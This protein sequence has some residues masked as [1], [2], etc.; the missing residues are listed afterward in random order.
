M[1]DATDGL[2]TCDTMTIR[3]EVTNPCVLTTLVFPPLSNQTVYLD[4]GDPLYFGV[5]FADQ[6][7]L[8]KGNYD[9]VSFCGARRYEFSEP[10][11]VTESEGRWAIRAESS[12]YSIKESPIAV[13]VWVTLDYLDASILMQSL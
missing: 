10:D 12:K 2:T 1:V 8:V 4:D 9:G 11:L 6:I 3:V 7:S 5:V 13:T